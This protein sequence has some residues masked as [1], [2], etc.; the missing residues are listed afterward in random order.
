[1]PTLFVALFLFGAISALF[2]PIKYGIL[3]DLLR[4]SELPSANA[5]VEGATFMAILLGTIA[6]GLAARGGG[7][8]AWFALMML[9]FSLV[10]WG[11]ALFI[12]RVGRA[13]PDLQVSIPTSC[14]RRW[15]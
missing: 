5:L 14:A 4:R 8:P 1:M 11:A 7:D 13:A 12:P 10:S 15:V 3:P 9:A 6:G 2:G